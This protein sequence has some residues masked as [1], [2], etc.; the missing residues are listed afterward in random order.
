[1]GE[2]DA[3]QVPPPG[4]KVADKLWAVLVIGLLVLIAGAFVAAFILSSDSPDA[5]TDPGPFFTLGTAALT[6]LLGLF[7]S[8][9][10][11]STNV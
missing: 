9:K 10:G 7:I 1:M 3:K 5:A 4:P 11:D 6:G 8:P 2:F